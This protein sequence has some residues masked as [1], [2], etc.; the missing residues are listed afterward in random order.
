MSQERTDNIE[1]RNIL[2]EKTFNPE[3]KDLVS[4]ITSHSKSDIENASL[5]SQKDKLLVQFHKLFYTTYALSESINIPEITNL[6]YTQD[7]NIGAHSELLSNLLKRYFNFLGCKGYSILVGD[8][9]KKSYSMS[10]T[11]Y[12]KIPS[13]KIF[14]GLYD[15]ILA[16]INSSDIGYITE[17]ED[18]N[19][20]A[21]QDEFMQNSIIYFIRINFLTNALKRELFHY[22][23]P[24]NDP[25][26]DNFIYSPILMLV[27][28]KRAVLPTELF[29][30]ISKDLAIPLYILAKNTAETIKPLADD[31]FRTLINKYEFVLQSCYNHGLNNAIVIKLSNPKSKEDAYIMDYIFSKLSFAFP[32]SVKFQ[33]NP[34]K[35][36]ILFKF[37][38]RYKVKNMLN[39]MSEDVDGNLKTSDILINSDISNEILLEMFFAG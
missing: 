2:R 21:I 25:N 32:E 19:R 28:P 5:N 30:I 13:Q 4:K 20:F 18:L 3:L 14:I 26:D 10:D 6:F 39:K 23:N 11:Y 7:A 33:I 9:K 17:S 38:F 22:N 31:D 35:I 8:Y 27:M 1:A 37:E 29:K 16:K 15:E 24:N 34:N 36:V 12:D